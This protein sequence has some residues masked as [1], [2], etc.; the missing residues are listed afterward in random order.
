MTINIEIT[1]TPDCGALAAIHSLAFSRGWST[2]DIRQSLAVDGTYAFVTKGAFAL[3]RYIE[4]EAEILTLA[5]LPQLRRQGLA[6]GIV[7]CV[8]NWLWQNNGK[9]VFLEVRESNKA[10]L[11]LYSKAGFRQLTRRE[12][13]YEGTEAAI[14]MQCHVK[15]DTATS[16]G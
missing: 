11:A 10:A 2:E 13:Y 5:V 4:P 8:L 15:Q 6:G 9:T 14:V 1:N 12:R 16:A 7:E 3:L